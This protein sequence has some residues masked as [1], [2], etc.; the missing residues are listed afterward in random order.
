[1][2]IYIYIFFFQKNVSLVDQMYRQGMI[3]YCNL[4]CDSELTM[5]HRIAGEPS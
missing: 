4:G 1:M 5:N 3:G 2:C